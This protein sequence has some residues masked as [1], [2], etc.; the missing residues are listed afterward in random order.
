MATLISF[1]KMGYHIDVFAMSIIVNYR[2]FS[3]SHVKSFVSKTKQKHTHPNVVNA[4]R[5]CRPCN[6]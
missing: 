5:H 6:T 3:H 1:Q 2:I 4:L